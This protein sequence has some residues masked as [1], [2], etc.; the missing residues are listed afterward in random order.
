[1]DVFDNN[2]AR[3][4][5]CKHVFCSNCIE[6]VIMKQQKCPICRTDLPSAEKCLVAPAQETREEEDQDSLENMG[7]SSSK[8]D[9]LL[10]ILDGVSASFRV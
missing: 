4:T 9:V 2:A 7:E 3:I 5:I 10:R 8:L 1:M 6:T